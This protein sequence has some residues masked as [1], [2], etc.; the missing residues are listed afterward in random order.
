M[1]PE[2]DAFLHDDETGYTT[3][4]QWSIDGFTTGDIFN[5]PA[6][7]VGLAVGFHYRED[8]LKD[9]PG[10]HT[11]NPETGE[12]NVFDDAFA[13]I[14]Q[15]KDK[16][17]AFFG[18]VDVPLLVDKHLVEALT[19]TASAR[20]N[21]VD[22]YGSGTTWKVGLNWQVTPEFRLRATRG[23]S[24]RAPALFELFLANATSTIAQRTDPC[25][26]YEANF[27]NGVIS[28]NVRDN[29]AADPRNL[30]PDYSGG[31]VE[32][33]VFTGGGFGV[34]EAETS[35]SLTVGFVWQP[36]FAD[37]SISVDYFDIEITDEV[38]QLGG[39]QI[40]L[41][42]YESNF[43]YAFGGTEPLCDLFD[44]SG[45]VQGTDNIMDSFINI[46]SQR[47]RGFDVSVRYHTALPWGDL[48]VDVAGTHQVEDFFQLFEE[49]FEDRN[50]LV[51]EPKTVASASFTFS[52]DA[53]SVNWRTHYI[54]KTSNEEKFGA[55]FILYRS[56]NYD[57]V[58]GT[59]VVWYHNF[60]ASYEMN[61]GLLILAGVANAFDKHPPQLTREGIGVDQYTMIGNSVLVNQYDM[62]GRRFYLN[63][64]QNF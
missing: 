14:T 21:D 62:Y 35:D 36:N 7:S 26:R 59:P 38:D 16:V 9:T 34:L 55:D 46:A 51:G 17:Y 37:L 10:E 13:G 54:G 41:S 6:G 20:Y 5:M 53:W 15:G 4:T 45:L 39:A 42:C 43:G 40:L 60:S 31:T 12:G 64:T 56:V 3:Y 25:R 48:L 57:A 8:K 11:F 61:N 2:V 24:F 44:R 23:T 29:C 49:T 28:P 50:G 63:L 32:A 27:Q 33:R 1:S 47:N 58:L 30:P 52:R 22:S 19:L 18:E